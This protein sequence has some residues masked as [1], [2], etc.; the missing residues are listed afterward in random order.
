IRTR[1]LTTTLFARLFLC[2]YFIHGIGG[3]KYDEVTD[4]IIE[5]FYGAAPPGFGIATAT[6][7]LPIRGAMEPPLDDREIARR[8]RDMRFNPDRWIRQADVPASE[9]PK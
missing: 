5:Q 8:L 6:L 3:A 1:A 7:R 2:D 4:Q 9:L